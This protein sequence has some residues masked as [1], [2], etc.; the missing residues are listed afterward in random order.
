MMKYE[1]RVYGTDDTLNVIFCIDYDDYEFY[2]VQDING[3]IIA[4][5]DTLEGAIDLINELE[6]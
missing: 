3:E 6:K 2:Q 5:F 4:G 1:E